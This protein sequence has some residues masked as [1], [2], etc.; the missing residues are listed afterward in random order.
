[1]T[2]KTLIRR[3]SRRRTLQGLGATMGAAALG[4]RDDGN[5]GGSESGSTGGGGSSGSGSESGSTSLPGTS[6]SGSSDGGSSEETGEPFGTDCGELSD[7]PSSELLAPVETIVVVM[8]EN[9]SFDHYFGALALEEG[10][11][12]D[13]LTGTESNPDLRGNDIAVFPSDYYVVEEDPP[14][15]W[16]S[17]REQWNNGANDGFVRAHQSDGAQLGEVVMGYHT[18]AQLPTLYGLA[19][20]YVLCERWFASVMGPTQPNRFHMHL[21]HSAGLMSNPDIGEGPTG[22]P[23]LFDRLTDAGVDSVYYSGGIPFPLAYGRTEGIEPMPNFFEAAAAGN[24]RPFVMIDPIFTAAGVVGNDD[25][26]P[27]DIRMGQA[28]LR[29][30]YEA[31]A[32]SPQWNRCLL[33]ITYDE[34]GGFYDH[35]SPPMTFDDVYPEFRQL[36][37]RVP[38]LVVGP[39]VRRGC[40]TSVVLDHVSVPATVSRRFGLEPLNSRC[41]MAN[42]I[43]SAIDPRYL[44]DPQPPA[45]LPPMLIRV[46]RTL[47]LP[48]GQTT[49]HQLEL[50]RMMDRGGFPRHLDGRG[51]VDETLQEILRWGVRL[52]ALQLIG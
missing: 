49:G 51:A 46:P 28:F 24:L 20:N 50:V 9:R 42:D 31:L 4:C 11:S 26:P 43:G 47:R 1:M 3:I 40:A 52:G 23:S 33:V 35:V 7:L 10:A 32:Q 38:S 44:D 34:H 2:R 21:G 15:G 18:R 36:G 19:S 14:H 22:Y 17:S 30:I 39:H 12:I 29:T 41:D 8:M 27:A 16:D 25:H 48:P 37:F 13:G 5:A 45:S 6:S